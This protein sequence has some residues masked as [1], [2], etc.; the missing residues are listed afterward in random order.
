MTKHN[1]N[2]KPTARTKTLLNGTWRLE[3]ANDD[4]FPSSWG[5]TVPVPALVDCAE[6]QYDW[7]AFTSF[8]Y[9]TTFHTTTSHDLAF[10][11]I[12][13]AMFGTEVWL[14][15]VHL[16]SDIA[17]YTSHEYDARNALR[18]GENELVVRVGRR[19]DL[20]PH[21]AVGKDQE[22]SEWIPGIWGDVY[23]LQCDNPRIKLIQVI[24]H[25]ENATA[26]AR[27]TVEN[28]SADLATV[29]LSTFISEKNSGVRVSNDQSQHF[30]IEP[31]SAAVG[32]VRHHVDGM[33]VWSPETPFLYELHAV[34][35]KV[36]PQTLSPE[37]RGDAC[38][39]VFGMR[40]F[41]I[42]D[43]DFYLNGKKILLRGGNIAF[44]RFLSDADRRTLPWEPHW[45]KKV[46]IDIPKAHHF[47]FFRIHL[48]HAYNRWYD[49][50]DEHGML[51]QDEWMFWTTT[52]TKEQITQEFTRW[53]QDNWNH[54]S[55]IIWD[56]L[57]ECTDP[58]VQREIVP[59][60]K[61][62]DP[63]RPWES[64]DFTED[65]PYIY[66]LGPVLNDRKLGF[67]RALDE[68]ENDT[69]PTMLNEFCWWWFGN[70]FKPTSL[71]DGVVERWLGP[72]WT[73]E[74]L[75]A[76]QSFLVTELVELF[77]R[78]RVDAIQPFVYLSNNTGPTAHWFIGDIKDLQPKPILQTLRNA[79]SP[80]GVSVE[81]W[82]RHFF[83]GEQRLLH[84]YLF[85]D[86]PIFHSGKIRYG[87][88]NS[89]GQWCSHTSESVAV[90]GGSCYVKQITI[91]FPNIPDTYSLRVELYEHSDTVPVAQSQK[92]AHVFE[93]VTIPA[94]LKT[95]NLCL[96]D[97]RGE[98]GDFLQR[99]E[100][101]Y[102]TPSQS[103]RDARYDILLVSEGS[104]RDH[105][106]KTRLDE[107]SEFVHSGGN[108]IVLE[109]EFGIDGKETVPLT[110]DVQL[111]IERRSDADRGGYDSYVFV[112]EFSHPLWNDITEEHLKMLNGG[113]GGE[114]VSQHHVIPDVP[115]TVHARCGLKLTTPAVMEIP[116]G[117]GT[118]L[119]YRIQLRGRLLQN[120][121]NDELFSRRDDPV[122]QQL[123]VN[124]LAY[125]SKRRH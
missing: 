100:L 93:P 99:H 21:S 78:M 4:R 107:I 71:M 115:F 6:P 20:P 84:V 70:D 38:A 51:L 19:E 114:M 102:H 92:I 79:F 61:K 86:H 41:T 94:G 35:R 15:G 60:M 36:E 98:V 123:L 59:A 2:M 117:R 85:N 10:I 13:Q 43:G 108:L 96:F 37:P 105:E 66:S 104:V 7:R 11:I 31:N 109:P 52:G 3:P 12:E 113:F 48:G 112:E 72:N 90:A 5:H 8:W 119:V 110:N 76:H 14:N 55:I 122:A 29:V 16:G 65:H 25:I 58:I 26:E 83:S 45:I 44:H 95:L 53:L 63:T 32:V 22:R 23:L 33:Q 81:L 47:N 18:E 91:A 30:T 9:R 69:K 24:P 77:R 62:L 74:Q 80:F 121:H 87:F 42:V 57:N 124:L 28:L 68:I 39:V 56:A 118:I 67:T 103:F 49:I 75:I 73:Q 54:P 46:L 89:D 97:K 116:V 40:E 111:T 82:D 101:S 125:A 50:A 106:Y 27:V 17:C 34:V 88:V 64:V 120:S 1:V